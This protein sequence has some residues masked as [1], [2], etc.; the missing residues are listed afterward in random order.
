MSRNTSDEI[1]KHDFTAISLGR[2]LRGAKSK[3]CFQTKLK[4]GKSVVRMVVDGRW[5]AEESP[6][7]EE[8]PYQ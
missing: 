4:K 1:T 2:K 7:A 6:E 5:Q 8:T 3:I